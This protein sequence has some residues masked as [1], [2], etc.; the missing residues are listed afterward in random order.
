[1]FSGSF[2][3]LFP[4]DLPENFILG[5]DDD[6]E[7]TNEADLILNLGAENVAAGAGD[8]V[9]LGG[10]TGAVVDGGAGDDRLLG[11][12]GDDVL[13]GGDGD[14]LLNGGFGD[15]KL[16]GG[17]GEDQ[18]FGGNGNDALD[19]GADDDEVYG[20]AGDDHLGGGAGNDTIVGGSG[21]DTLTGA[22]GSD[23]YLFFGDFGEDI[24]KERLNLTGSAEADELKFDGFSAD[25]ATFEVIRG[26]ASTD[27]L[28]SFA[29]GENSV[30]I[31]RQ[32]GGSLGSA[33]VERAVFDDGVIDLTDPSALPSDS[34]ASAIEI[35]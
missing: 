2:P 5:I 4:F 12:T 22:A 7:G 20:G 33:P 23:T 25:D 10:G 32:F 13:Q 11:G 35:A 15:D 19:G 30:L 8:D 27:L 26:F 16:R 14:D 17:N 9:Y 1:M 28:I 29:D 21:N 34:A 3:F 31:E 24:V 6:V 18:L